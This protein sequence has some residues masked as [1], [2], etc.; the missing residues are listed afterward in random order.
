M[1]PF[2]GRRQQLRRRPSPARRGRGGGPGAV[3]WRGHLVAGEDRPQGR[4]VRGCPEL[5]LGIVA[6]EVA[7]E[8]TEGELHVVCCEAVRVKQELGPGLATNGVVYRVLL[9]LGDF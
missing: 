3:R 4:V 9:S 6:A 7:V 1:A 5:R 2:P 8:S